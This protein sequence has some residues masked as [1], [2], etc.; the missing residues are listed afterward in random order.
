[1]PLPVKND[2]P[3]PVNIGSQA[4]PTTVL[5]P[6][7]TVVHPEEVSEMLFNTMVIYG[8]TGT[9]KTS[10]IGEFAKYIYEKTG[11][12]T[13][14]IS[15]DGGGYAPVQDLINVGV[16]EVWRLVEE[17]KPLPMLIHASRGLWPKSLSNGKRV[18]NSPLTTNKTESLKD[19]GAYAVEG[20]ASIAS[21]A[22]RYLVE[23]GQK[24]N[25][26]VVSK[27]AEE[28]DFGEVSFGAPSR[29]HYNFVQNLILDLIRNFSALD[30]PERI[31]Y[32]SLEGKG[33]DKLTRGLQYGPLVAGQAITAAIPQYVGDCI[34]FEDFSEDKGKDPNNAG[35]K[36]IELGVRAWFSSHP[37]TQTGVMWPAKSRLVPSKVEE[38]KKR[39]GPQGYFLLG[40]KSLRDYLY[41]QDDLLKSST[42][43]ARKWKAQVDASRKQK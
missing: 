7:P 6:P 12:I 30:G 1:M 2:A 26:D 5:P 14:L 25:E 10:Q 38:F 18:S 20:W 15:M 4:S 31:L 24:I 36:L 34:H 9:R 23:K 33:E 40:N 29:G 8:P 28:S 19:V 27:F 35:Q 16:I 39:M 32:T 3:T 22:I 37:D 21:A 13:R 43:E 41:T 11:K 17:E 42:E